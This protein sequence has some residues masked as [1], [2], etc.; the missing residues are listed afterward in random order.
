MSHSQFHRMKFILRHAWLN[1]WDKH[2]TTGRINQVPT[3]H[4]PTHAKELEGTTVCALFIQCVRVFYLS[5]VCRER[6]LQHPIIGLRVCIIVSSL[7]TILDDQTN[8]QPPSTRRK[9]GELTSIEKLARWTQPAFPASK[10]VSTVYGFR[11]A[12]LCDSTWVKKIGNMP[13]NCQP[14]KSLRGPESKHPSC[15]CHDQLGVC[16]N[17]CPCSVCK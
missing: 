14:Q 12:G 9:R 10:H 1:L 2:M 5:C 4:R 7:L 8:G 17:A 13:N 16:A 15:I 3:H 11:D 6:I